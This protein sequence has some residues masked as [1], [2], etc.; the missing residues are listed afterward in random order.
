M[1]P[2]GL[3]RTR[4]TFKVPHQWLVLSCGGLTSSMWGVE[5]EE[6]WAGEEKE[7]NGEAGGW[8]W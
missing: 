6:A 5:E 1:P 7:L 4:S 2:S 8:W 3:D